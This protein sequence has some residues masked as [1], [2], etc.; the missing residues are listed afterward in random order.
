M[1]CEDRVKEL[2]DE[3]GELKRRKSEVDEKIYSKD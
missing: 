3:L 1:E 2:E